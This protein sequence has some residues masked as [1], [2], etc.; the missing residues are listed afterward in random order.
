MK[1]SIFFLLILSYC[2]ISAQDAAEYCSKI[3]AEQFRKLYKSSSLAYPGDSHIDVK[4][5]KLDLNLTINPGN[6]NGVISITAKSTINNLTSVILDLR[7]AL[8]VSSITCNGN[9]LTFTHANDKITVTLNKAY[10]NGEQFTLLITYG[11]TPTAGGGFISNASISFYDNSAQKDVI[12]SLSEPYGSKDWWP[13]KDDPA[14]KADSSDVWITA[15]AWFTSVSNGSLVEVVTNGNGTKTYKWKN[16]YPIAPYLISIAMTDYYIYEDSWNYAPGKSLPIIHYSYPE[17]WT[18]DRKNALDKTKEMIEIYSDKFGLYPYI[19]EKYGHAEFSWGGGM[20]HQTV[21]SMGRFAMNSTHTIAHELGHQW[22]GDKVTCKDWQNIWLNEGFASY[23]EAV[24]REGIEGREGYINEIRDDMLGAKNAFG[25]LY[26]QD[27][28][29][30]GE[31]FNSNRSYKKGSVVVHMLRGVVGDSGKFYTI[32]RNYLN[33]PAL[34]FGVATT[35][36]LKRHAENVT[37]QNLQYFFDEWVYGENYPNYTITWGTS[38]A[39]I[40]PDIVTVKVTIQQQTNTT[41]PSYFTMPVQ[42]KFKIGV[43]DTVVTVFNNQQNQ[44]FYIRIKGNP[45]SLSFD[46]DEWIL[47]NEP[48]IIKSN[49]VVSN[50]YT[51]FQNYPNPFNPGTKILYMLPQDADVTIKVFDI[52]GR[53]IAIL[54]NKFELSGFHS[55]PFSATGLALPSGIYYY[56]LI[57]GNHIETKKMVYIK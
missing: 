30:E 16:H 15:D 1:K 4:Y 51:L 27:I 10:S 40:Y 50:E 54:V 21:T 35:E 12:A 47:R 9:N 7:S 18:E 11:G 8:T 49:Y 3:K 5:Y 20:E 56:S 32:L 29:N 42:L 46:P 13:C 6:I 39:I 31:I 41:N 53:E 45:T 24:Y 23:T 2:I 33:D 17:N 36:D 34:S 55:I 19:K 38:D 44:T 52:L 25:T 37:G 48:V 26:V 28:T 14:D 57:A 43:R 22:F